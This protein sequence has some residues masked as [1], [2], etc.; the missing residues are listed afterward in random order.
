MDQL[1]EFLQQRARLVLEA[2]ELLDTAQAEKRDLTGEERQRFEANIDQVGELDVKIRKLERD[3]EQLRQ[4]AG[5]VPGQPFDPR[6]IDGRG[7]GPPGRVGRDTLVLTS[8]QRMSDWY[9][10]RHGYLAGTESLD[11][12]DG[13]FS[14]G[15]VCRALVTGE[16]RHLSELERRALAEGADA[17]GGVLVPEFLSAHVIDRARAQSVLFQAGATTVPME[18]DTLVLARMTGGNTAAW[19]AENAA[20]TT[21]DQTWERVELKAKT[22]VVEQIMSRELFDDATDAGM[23]AIEREIV[24]ALALKLDLAGLEGSG[25]GAEPLGIAGVA[26]VSSVS[27]GVNGLKPTTYDQLVQAVFACRKQNS[28]EPTAAIYHPRDLETYALLKDT[29]NQPLRKPAALEQ[30]PLLSTSQIATNVTQGTSG[31]TSRA[32]VGDFRELIVGMRT[33]IRIQF[34]QERFSDNLQVAFLAWLRADF[35]LAHPEHFTKI[36]GLRIV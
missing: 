30:L 17:T 27:M 32:Y 26:G 5:G 10:A 36:V 25:A 11:G 23:R 12:R 6:A 1:T 19:K 22:L 28:E 7:D 20:V 4:L 35:E 21:S 29:T 13:D 16:R 14:L 8:E 3:R 31:D 34:L 15:R 2:K 24:Q 9:R 18:S 33:Q